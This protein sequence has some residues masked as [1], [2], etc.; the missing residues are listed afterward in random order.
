MIGKEKDGEGILVYSNRHYYIGQFK[1]DEKLHGKEI[2]TNGDSYDGDFVKNKWH[3]NGTLINEQKGYKYTGNP[4]L[5]IFLTHIQGDFK[6][7][8]RHGFGV[9]EIKKDIV[10]TGTF[11]NNCRQGK[12]KLEK[13]DCK[14][15]F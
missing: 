5:L 9:E 10:Y 3:G 12:G 8:C 11:V 2:Y 1:K 7:G 6:N 13:K 15:I 14:S 4:L